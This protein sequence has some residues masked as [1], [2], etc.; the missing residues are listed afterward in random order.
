METL[1]W[2]LWND[3]NQDQQKSESSL[4]PPF[5]PKLKNKSQLRC[6]E[7]GTHNFVRAKG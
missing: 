7:W 2:T 5:T 3:E 4:F 6:E 1:G